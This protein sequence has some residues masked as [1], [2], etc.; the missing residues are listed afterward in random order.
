MSLG[1][2]SCKFEY[3]GK[4]TRLTLPHDT[5]EVSLEFKA[6]KGCLTAASSDQLWAEA[7]I[8]SFKQDVLVTLEPNPGV[9][10]RTANLFVVAGDA[11]L[12]FTVTQEGKPAP[13]A[14]PAPA[15][16]QA[17]APALAPSPIST[18][19]PGAPAPEASPV[20]VVEPAPVVTEAPAEKQEPPKA[21]PVEL[22]NDAPAPTPEAPKE[23]MLEVKR[24]E[25]K[26]P[27]EAQP[28]T[29]TTPAPAEPATAPLA[30]AAG[31]AVEVKE[32]KAPVLADVVPSEGKKEG[33]PAKAEDPKSEVLQAPKVEPVKKA[34]EAAKPSEPVKEPA[35]PTPAITPIPSTPAVS[36]LPPLATPV[37]PG[38]DYEEVD[39]SDEPA[40]GSPA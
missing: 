1:L 27:E 28:P 11:P 4:S 15:P 31:P 16:T 25:Q 40:G 21:M 39:L 9:K 37:S 30:P 7:A 6:E 36:G 38:D 23:P 34:D 2:K 8:R 32:T 35:G 24:D 17:P 13:V 33:A 12:E 10:P 14:A 5:S 26:A 19:V 20:K 29:V 3:K 18:P 22:K